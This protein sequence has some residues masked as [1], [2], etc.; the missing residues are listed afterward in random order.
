VYAVLLAVGGVAYG[1]GAV[2]FGKWPLRAKGVN[3]G[4]GCCNNP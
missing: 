3:T 4:T 2:W 1:V